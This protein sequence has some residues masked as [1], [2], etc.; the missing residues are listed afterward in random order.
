M[1]VSCGTA[2]FSD[3]RSLFSFLLVSFVLEPEFR[4]QLGGVV[5]EVFLDLSAKA[6]REENLIMHEKRGK[7]HRYPRSR[8]IRSRIVDMKGA[9]LLEDCPAQLEHDAHGHR[10]H[11]I[12]RANQRYER[13]RQP[14][15]HQAGARMPSQLTTSEPPP[16]DGSTVRSTRVIK[17]R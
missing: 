2:F 7:D 4:F 15:Q 12:E 10:V 13:L 11:R 8:Y 6:Q 14:S 9:H 5:L 17:A 16:G 1:G 3:R